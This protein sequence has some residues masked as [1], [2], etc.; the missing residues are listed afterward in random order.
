MKRNL[1][2]EYCRVYF[3]CGG[4]GDLRFRVESYSAA[5]SRDVK[6][7]GKL[8]AIRKSRVEELGG[9]LQFD[10]IGE[11]NCYFPNLEPELRW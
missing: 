8:A 7:R 9:E 6:E 4:L 3:Q 11:V 2:R 5:F 10:E 1:P